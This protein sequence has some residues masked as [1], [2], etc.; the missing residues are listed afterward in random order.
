[1]HGH[2]VALVL[3][4]IATSNL[5]HAADDDWGNNR[6]YFENKRGVGSL[7]SSAFPS[8]RF[9]VDEPVR[10]RSILYSRQDIP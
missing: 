3:L 8:K 6:F 2:F 7:P 4:A 1:M 5:A 10:V 9:Y